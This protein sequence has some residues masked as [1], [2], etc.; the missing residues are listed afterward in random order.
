MT[1]SAAPRSIHHVWIYRAGASAVALLL[2]WL[3]AAWLGQPVSSMVLGALLGIVTMSC[4]SELG[5]KLASVLTS[6]HDDNIQVEQQVVQ[7]I[8]DAAPYLDVLGEQLN[9]AMQD[10]E[11]GFVALIELIDKTQ[12]LADAQLGRIHETDAN[13]DELASVMNEKLMFDQ[14]VGT[15]L[16]MFVYNKGLE[17][18]ANLGRMKRL[19]EVKDMSVLVS[20][21]SDVARQTNM[22]AI[23]AAIEA[24][25]AGDTGR[26]FAVVAAEIRKLSKHTAG[27]AVDIAARI[28]AATQGIDAELREATNMEAHEA[29]ANSI[30]NV[31]VQIKEMQVRFKAATAHMLKVFS[32]IKA[33]HDDILISLSDAL[34]HVQLHDVLRQRVD[35]VEEALAELNEHLSDVATQLENGRWESTR[36]TNLKQKLDIQLERYVMQSQVDTHQQVTGGT[37]VSSNIR[38]NIE[39]F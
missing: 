14:Q 26:G 31:M 36:L 38:P 35:L 23:N 5:L 24:A 15:I 17:H 27:L 37:T 19:H 28:A 30:N 8:R 6:S 2:A 11:A 1:P 13:G 33:G 22:L 34:G 10:A 18:D 16:E 20:D 32:E 9:G 7:E 21:I 4:L 25:R 12:R 29:S 3:L 39:L